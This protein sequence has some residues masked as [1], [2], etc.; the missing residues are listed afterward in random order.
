MTFY[1]SAAMISTGM[2]NNCTLNGFDRLSLVGYEVGWLWYDVIALV[3]YAMLFLT[4]TYLVLFFI[5]KILHS[6]HTLYQSGNTALVIA[7]TYNSPKMVEL[8]IN[9]GACVDTQK[10]VVIESI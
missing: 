7:V 3:L 2:A 10:K 8:L 4:I 1:S 6:L 5:K 9:A